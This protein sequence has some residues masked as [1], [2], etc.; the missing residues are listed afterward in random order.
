MIPFDAAP[1]RAQAERRLRRRVSRAVD[2]RRPRPRRGPTVAAVAALVVA[3]AAAG[4]AA[5]QTPRLGG[6]LSLDRRF[7][8]GGDQ[9]R[10]A[11]FYNRF[12]AEVSSD[13]GEGLYLFVSLDARFYDF[14]P[15]R[16]G[17]EGGEL[18]PPTELSVW[19]A[20][21]EL[22]RFL[23]D[24][25]DLTVGKQRVRWGT[26]DELNPTDIV[27]AHDLTDLVDF[28][29]RVP[30]W[31]LRA[32][33]YLGEKTLTGVWLP[34]A[35]PP[36]LP[37]G[38][39]ALFQGDLTNLVP[40]GARVVALEDRMESA[41]RR[42]ADGV[43]GIR[44]AGYAAGVDYSVSWV[45]GSHGIP[46]PTR[47]ELAPDG[48][49]SDPDGLTG[50]VVFGVPRARFLGADM[51]T[52]LGGARL[53]GEAT[54]VLPER[55]ETTA[56]LEGEGVVARRLTVDDR[57][58]IRSTVGVDYTFPGGWYGN[59]QWA[60]GL[61]LERGADAVHDYVVG[62]VEK[63]FL[64]DELEMALGGAVEA[65]SWSDPGEDLGW[66]FFPELTYSP[67][68][69]LEWVVGTFLVGGRGASLFGVW[70][71]ADQAYARVKVS[72]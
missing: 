66:G 36:L 13:P 16:S 30:T 24:D 71:D 44:F 39:A 50:K 52:D 69:N 9:V 70:D 10:V 61:F 12:R 15:G 64:R 48:D 51:V 43:Y 28:T 18:G 56:L 49:A 2:K 25:L 20:Y 45:D 38:G 46:V 32:D 53:W 54:L 3:L 33:Y 60:H 26:A 31:A 63:G 62:R 57:P 67:V 37:R 21:V 58:F 65:G 68:D 7:E 59:L 47:L 23:V 34:T 8:I 5:A 40:P 14:S 41:S 27:N 42:P 11:D 4:G 35:R 19:E 55:V 1:G 29:A 72:F 17:S 22:R 6:F